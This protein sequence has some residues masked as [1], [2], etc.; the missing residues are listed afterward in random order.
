MLVPLLAVIQITTPVESP[1]A[2]MLKPEW[3]IVWVTAA[4]TVVTTVSLVLLAWQIKIGRESAEKQLRA[5]VVPDVIS[6]VN[7]VNPL[8]DEADPPPQTDARVSRPKIGPR[9]R[10]QIKNAGQTPAHNMRHWGDMSF[11]EL[12][13]TGSLSERGRT[14]RHHPIVLGPGIVASKNFGDMPELTDEQASWLRNGT[15]AIYVHGEILYTDAF[16]KDRRTT[17]RFMHCTL[18]GRMGVTTDLTFCD[19]GND[20]N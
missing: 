1:H 5:Y 4:Y 18:T 3:V 2:W 7:V 19:E 11:R 20:G 6:I 9:A 14:G 10:I 17:Y 12:P 13:L 8:P 15:Y 16:G